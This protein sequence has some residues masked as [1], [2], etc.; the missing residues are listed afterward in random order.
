MLRYN[1]TTRSNM[2]YI[3]SARRYTTSKLHS[4]LAK[5]INR[6]TLQNWMKLTEAHI[7]CVEQDLLLE[8]VT[9]A[10]DSNGIYQEKFLNLSASHARHPGSVRIPLQVSQ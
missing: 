3:A 9:H 5:D 8:N 2:F 7:I 6:V 1:R 10:N 4:E